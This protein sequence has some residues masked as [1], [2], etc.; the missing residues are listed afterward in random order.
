MHS[1]S[2]W[3]NFVIFI[4]SFT[5]IRN[6]WNVYWSKWAMNTYHIS[7]VRKWNWFTRTLHVHLQRVWINLVRIRFICTLLM[8]SASFNWIKKCSRKT[9]PLELPYWRHIVLI[10]AQLFYHLITAN[11]RIENVPICQLFPHSFYSTAIYWPE[12]FQFIIVICLLFIVFS[13]QT[14]AFIHGYE[15]QQN[16]FTRSLSQMIC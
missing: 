6:E 5:E 11:R 10:C 14:K 3:T 15:Q 12:I 1:H 9:L 16:A 8:K 7:R 13:I 4:D 2:V